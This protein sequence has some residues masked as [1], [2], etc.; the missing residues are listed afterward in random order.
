MRRVLR[1][2]AAA[3]LAAAAMA[4]GLVGAVGPAQAS[5]THV[6][7]VIAG[8]KTACVAWHS[9]MTG[10]DVLNAVADVTKRYDGLIVQIDGKPTSGTADNTHYWAYWH[11]TKG[12]W[13]YSSEGAGT[14]LAPAGSVEGWA[15]S[16]GTLTKP[17][18]VSYASICHDATS[19]APTTKPAST[20]PASTSA[21]AQVG[22]ASSTS[23]APAP[24]SSHAGVS[25]APTTKPPSRHKSA[26]A[27]AATTT[28]LPSTVDSSSARPTP[29]P[30][31][32]PKKEHSASAA[33]AAGT[34]A[35]LVAAAA[36]GG[37]AF[38]RMRRQDG[39]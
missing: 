5:P 3:G 10:D 15:Y 31:A 1:L 24:L 2:A 23:E 18:L 8:D 14:Y 32:S 37:V 21:P 36:I 6:G 16:N 11:N 9:G 17:P 20:R 22:Q 28:G 33:P 25:A 39:N 30:T 7:I 13:V 4:I 29:T 19:P 26:T 38:W 35:G 27:T 34:A 12:Y